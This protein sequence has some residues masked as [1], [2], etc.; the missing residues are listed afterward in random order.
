MNKQQNQEQIQALRKE[1]LLAI[2]DTTLNLQ[3]E[4][5]KYKQKFANF[6]NKKQIDNKINLEHQM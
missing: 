1:N 3:S 5:K 4:V 6:T 2:K